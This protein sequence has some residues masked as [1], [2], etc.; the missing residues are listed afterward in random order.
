MLSTK[1]QLL[2]LHI[3][4]CGLLD[5]ILLLLSVGD[6]VSLVELGEGEKLRLDVVLLEL[7]LDDGVVVPEDEGIVLSEV[8]RD[9]HL[10]VDIVLHLE[11][12]AVEVVR[13]DVHENGD[14]GLEVVHVVELEA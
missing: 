14:V 5:D 3:E 6:D 12:V 11:I 4:G 10:G 1:R 13:R 7:T 8:L 9:A 2:Q